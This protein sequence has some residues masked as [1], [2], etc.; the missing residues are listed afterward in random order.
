[1]VPELE[2]PEPA[3]LDTIRVPEL[4]MVPELVTPVVIVTVIPLGIILVSLA[5]GTTPP[6]QVLPTF[7]FPLIAA[8]TVA[9]CAS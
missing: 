8:V 5:A 4:V 1:M 9:A 2:I 6:T 3:E 7:Q